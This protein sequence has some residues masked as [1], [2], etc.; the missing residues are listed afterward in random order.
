[1]SPFCSPSPPTCL[2]SLC[3]FNLEFC[4]YYF[5]D[6]YVLFSLG[7]VVSFNILFSSICSWTLNTKMPCIHSLLGL[8]HFPQKCYNSGKSHVADRGSDFFTVTDV[9]YCIASVRQG[10]LNPSSVDVQFCCLQFLV[11]KSGAVGILIWTSLSL[12]GCVS[13]GGTTG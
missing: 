9:H 10:L 6:F 3:D 12:V 13:K 5:L 2:C 4:A 8:A 11:M 7:I 1:M